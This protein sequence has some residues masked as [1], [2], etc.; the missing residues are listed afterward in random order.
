M[1]TPMTLGWPS[2]RAI[3]R[4]LQPASGCSTAILAKVRETYRTLTNYQ[5]ERVL[6]VEEAKE[7]SPS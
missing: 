1:L 2:S 6:R 3:T 5:F 4:G 7:P